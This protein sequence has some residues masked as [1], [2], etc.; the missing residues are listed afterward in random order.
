MNTLTPATMIEAAIKTEDKDSI[1]KLHAAISL[2]E[3][4]AVIV[5]MT[6]KDEPTKTGELSLAHEQIELAANQLLETIRKIKGSF[7]A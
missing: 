3:E 1:Q 2:L 5:T 7:N 6:K 4:A